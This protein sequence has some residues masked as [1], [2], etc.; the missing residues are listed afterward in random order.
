MAEKKKP[1]AKKKATVKKTPAK[2]KR[3]T[4]KPNVKE[5]FYIVGMGASPGGLEAFERF[6]QNM[7]NDS[8]M[9]FILVP[10]LDPTHV[11]RMPERVQKSIKMHVIQVK[12]SFRSDAK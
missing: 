3:P 12:N 4:A 6:F 5:D 8:G 1:A 10:H 11:S 9:G 7:S 2:E